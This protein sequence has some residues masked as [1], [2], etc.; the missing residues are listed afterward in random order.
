MR[1]R[2]YRGRKSRLCWPTDIA[3]DSSIIPIV[4]TLKFRRPNSCAIQLRSLF[5][6]LVSRSRSNNLANYWYHVNE[7]YV[8]A[9][10][11]FSMKHACFLSARASE[12]WIP[13]RQLRDQSFRNRRD[14]DRC[15][16]WISILL[17]ISREYDFQYLYATTTHYI[18]IRH[19]CDKEVARSLFFF[20]VLLE[21]TFDLK[22]FSRKSH[23]GILRR[24]FG[25]YK[26]S[27]ARR[28]I[29]RLQNKIN[30]TFARRH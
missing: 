27:C 11:N 25:N 15:P 7:N 12:N 4:P 1:F 17:I 8:R 22:I 13:V 21:L 20:G 19:F 16:S 29:L 24:R 18:I 28:L 26:D 3:Y 30:D 2:F 6:I 10:V 23:V 14:V 9:T 5:M